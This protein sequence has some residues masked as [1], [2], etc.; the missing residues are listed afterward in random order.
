VADVGD[1]IG[2]RLQRAVQLITHGA[3]GG[4]KAT[5]L[6]RRA[7]RQGIVEVALRQAVSRGR[8]FSDGAS[9]RTRQQQ[10]NQ[11]RKCQGN[12]GRERKPA[13]QVG[14][15][16]CNVAQRLAQVH[17]PRDALLPGQRHRHPHLAGLDARL[18][19][20]CQSPDDQRI[21]RQVPA[22]LRAEAVDGHPACRVDQPDARVELRAELQRDRIQPIWR[23][24]ASL[25]VARCAV[26]CLLLHR[27]GGRG[28][29]GLADVG[30]CQGL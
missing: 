24:S 23:G 2:A 1:Q 4:G 25:A 18:F 22:G 8:E 16:C 10:A 26:H 7:G 11:A 14:Q 17:H 28:Q 6:V 3:E 29:H 27:V 19:A 20:S 12:H 13:A 5:Q 9:D 15:H 21:T 30:D